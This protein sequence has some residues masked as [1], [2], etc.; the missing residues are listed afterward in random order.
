M[1]AEMESSQSFLSQVW[2][3]M[4]AVG[5]NTDTWLSTWLG[6]PHST[7]AEYQGYLKVESVSP[8][9]II[10][11]PELRSITSAMVIS[12]TKFKEREHRPHFLMGRISVTLQ[13]ILVGQET[14]PQPFWGTVTCWRFIFYCMR[15]LLGC[16]F[17]V[18][19]PQI[20]FCLSWFDV[21]FCHFL[22]T[23]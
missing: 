10:Q 22:A 8:F 21:G 6:C 2:W 4:L 13:E 9:F 1:T 20:P 14:P 15:P 16:A 3:L 23:T 18:T 19:E 7:V 5:Q 12:P 11:P 17:W